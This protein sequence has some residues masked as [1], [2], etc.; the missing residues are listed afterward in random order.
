MVL[1]AGL[2]YTLGRRS[3]YLVL[4]VLLTSTALSVSAVK[5]F[6]QEYV[7]LMLAPVFLLLG[8]LLV[9]LIRVN[10]G[11]SIV[12]ERMQKKID[13]MGVLGALLLGM[14]FALSFCPTTAVWFFGLLALTM[15]AKAGVIATLLNGMGIN[16]PEVALPGGTMI[17]PVVYGVGTALPCCSWLSCW[18]TAC[19]P[20]GRHS[21]RWPR[22][23]GGLAG[24]RLDLRGAGCLFLLEHVFEV[25]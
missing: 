7:H 9:G 2:L 8:M 12:T 5:L 24:D 20:W 1:G 19:N 17:L 14:F 16:L 4:A 3:L 23:N 22:S 6:L 21:M 13:A 25:I 15:G 10:P 11:G 18:L